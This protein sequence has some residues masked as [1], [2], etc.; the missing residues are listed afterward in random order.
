MALLDVRNLK[1]VYTTRLGSNQVQ[2]LSNVN[3]YYG[4][5]WFRK[6]YAS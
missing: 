2:A 3:G 6:D 1:K 5:V 4:R